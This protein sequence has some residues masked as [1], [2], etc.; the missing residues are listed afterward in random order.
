MFNIEENRYW[1]EH[2]WIIS[3]DMNISIGISFIFQPQT[4]SVG[5]TG[6]HLDKDY[7][8]IQHELVLPDHDCH[9]FDTFNSYISDLK[10]GNP[11]D[12][13]VHFINICFTFHSSIHVICI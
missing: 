11:D 1:I 4:M 9:C 6:I 12:L 3:I 8:Q 10:I 13:Q 5:V 2:L 7:L